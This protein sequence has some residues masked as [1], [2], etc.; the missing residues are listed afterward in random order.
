[1]K[2]IAFDIETTGTVAGVDRIVEIGAVCFENG[3]PVS[4]FSTLVNP[5]IPIP[6]GASRVNGI[7]DDMV[8]DQPTIDQV[9]PSFA[10][11]CADVVM[12]AHNSAF[13]T[14]FIT[15]D[16]K[17]FEAPAPRGTIIDTLSISRKVFP[18]LLNYKLE[19]LVNHL[20][21]PKGQFH[22]A[23]ADAICCGHLFGHILQKVSN[24]VSIE[25]LIALTGRP[26]QKFPQ[27][28][29]QPK[30]LSLLDI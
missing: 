7:T 15:S 5:K 10:E 4:R 17:I 27:I 20:C 3:Q 1:M 26:E 11:F 23:E 6:A 16:V 13:D 22:R 25:N 19:T 14:Q 12:V 9:L 24:P 2:Y 21:I 8:K 30:Q 18:G 29:P 28:I